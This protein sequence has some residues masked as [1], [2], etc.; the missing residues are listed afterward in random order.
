MVLAPLTAAAKGAAADGKGTG[1]GLIAARIS[2]M[3][4][5]QDMG[6]ERRVVEDLC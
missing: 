2:W 5:E 3:G 1:L 4:H 6:M